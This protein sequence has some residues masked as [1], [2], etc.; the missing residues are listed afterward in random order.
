MSEPEPG[1]VPVRLPSRGRRLA[2]TILVVLGVLLVVVSIL[3]N[4]VK[5][6]ALDP[7]TFR[8]TSEELI[9]NEQ[10]RNQVAATMV[11]RLYDSVDVSTELEDQLPKNLKGLSGPLAGISRELADRAARELLQRPS[12]QQLFVTASS[13]AQ[14][15]F[16][17]VL[18]GDTKVV[19]TTNGNVVLDL[20]PL[21]LELGDRFNFVSDLA[22]RIPQD[23]AQVTIL[24]SDDLATAQ[25]ITQ[26]LKAVANWIWALAVAAWAAALW[27]VP[28]RRRQAVRSIGIGLIVA[29]A[30]LLV[31][32]AFAGDYFVD[33][34]VVTESVR[35]AASEV[36][37]IL[38]DS[39]AASAWVAVWVGVLGSVGAWLTG[40]GRRATASR[41]WLAPHLLRPE[42]AY[43]VFAVVVTVALWLL[44]IQDFKTTVILLLLSVLGY[45]TLRRQVAREAPNAEPVE[46][47]GGMKERLAD[48]RDSFGN[49]P[50]VSKTDELERLAKLHADGKLTDEEFAAAKADLFG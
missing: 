12:V 2:A 34:I 26:A 17:A 38:T 28:G 43:A 10:I 48:V 47:F 33:N 15:E 35:P 16:I 13:A 7:A 19:E 30:L 1:P 18:E 11:E 49:Q 3:A 20:R 32:R 40:P 42:V 27:L 36:W 6:E 45:E 46:L 24:K 41:R 23:S 8:G 39:L 44:P 50:Q 37:R 21:V 22:D 29:G 5:R 4:Y 25:D 14:K 31:I 9:A